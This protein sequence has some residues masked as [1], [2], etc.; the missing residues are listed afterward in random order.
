VIGMIGVLVP[1]VVF[2]LAP[3][4]Q[5]TIKAVGSLV[6]RSVGSVDLEF[7]LDSSSPAA[8][9]VSSGVV[10]LVPSNIFFA[11][12]TDDTM[13]VLV[14]A[15]IFGIAMAASERR[16]GR[17]FFG[18]LESLHDACLLIFQWLNLLV[19]VGFIALIAPQIARLGPKAYVM[20]AHFSYVFFG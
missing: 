19:P 9:G 10:A 6:G 13:Q 3:F 4:D 18:V 16:T 1:A 8:S 11:L 5:D 7:Y 15:A 12:S 17:S 20:L 14:F 2:R